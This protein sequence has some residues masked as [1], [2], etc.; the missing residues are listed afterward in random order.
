MDSVIRGVVVYLIL[1][2]IFRVSGRRT[3]AQFTTFDFVV[4]LFLSETIQQA[5]I[6][7]DHSLTAA[8]IL[9]LTLL[10]A[11]I[12]VTR[13]GTNV[14]AARKWIDDPPVVL[15]DHGRLLKAQ[16]NANRVDEEEI[17]AAARERQGLE[18][19]DQVKFA[20]LESSG[21]ISIIPMER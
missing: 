18:R 12:L 13:L 1:M 8:I 3:L 5:L 20:V 9:V 11:D 14:K 4:L 17:L 15:V 2:I 19:M 21:E 7:D 6:G 10:G 16:M